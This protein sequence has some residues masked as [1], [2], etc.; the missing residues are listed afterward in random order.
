VPGDL[1]VLLHAVRAQIVALNDECRIV[2]V[3]ELPTQSIGRVG[4]T[5]ST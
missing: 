1:S 5:S 2:L 3:E 4:M